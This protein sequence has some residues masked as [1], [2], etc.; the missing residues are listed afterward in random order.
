MPNFA[1]AANQGTVS[2][3]LSVSIDLGFVHTLSPVLQMKGM[4]PTAM[5]NEPGF[6]EW[7]LVIP[8]QKAYLC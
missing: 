6:P 2:I 8:T 3:L 5:D 1:S 7:F 4:L